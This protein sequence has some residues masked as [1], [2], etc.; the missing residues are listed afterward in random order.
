MMHMTLQYLLKKGEGHG[1]DKGQGEASPSH[2]ISP[3]REPSHPLSFQNLM[4]AM[5]Q[6]KGQGRKPEK[7][8]KGQGERPLQLTAKKVHKPQPRLVRRKPV[9]N[10]P[11]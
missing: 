2:P 10:H 7:Q 4:K 8:R 11:L 1:N 3:P 9:H 6:G 5:K